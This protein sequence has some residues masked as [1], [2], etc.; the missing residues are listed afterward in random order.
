MR[1]SF[2]ATSR[3]VRWLLLVRN[4]NGIFRRRRLAMNS[5]A[6]GISS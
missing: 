4:M 5:A 3:R 1:E 2:I 6:P